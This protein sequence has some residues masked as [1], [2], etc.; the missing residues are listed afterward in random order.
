MNK[1]EALPL[2]DHST[3]LSEINRLDASTSIRD[4]ASQW[5]QA[6]RKHKYQRPCFT[7]KTDSTQAQASETLLHS[8]N[9]LD[10][11]HKYQRPCFTVK[12]G[13]TQTQVSE[14]LLHN[15]N[16]LDASTRIRELASQWKQARRKH[17]DKRASSLFSLTKRPIYSYTFFLH[18][19]TYVIIAKYWK[20][21]RKFL[22]NF[23][24]K[25]ELMIEDY[26]VNNTQYVRNKTH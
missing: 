21:T 6:R 10:R 25:F 4:L 22:R 20:K 7:V 17:K 3:A 5:K 11:K 14:T 23:L 2:Q 8:E 19:K 9:R 18:L 24:R 1:Q 26:E 13:S 16:R 12:T 15:E